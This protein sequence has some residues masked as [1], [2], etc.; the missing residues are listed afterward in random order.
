MQLD[1]AAILAGDAP[2]TNTADGTCNRER[3][4]YRVQEA[5]TEKTTQAND[6]KGNRNFCNRVTA[7]TVDFEHPK[8]TAP[9]APENAPGDGGLRSF[10]PETKTAISRPIL[11]Y[12]LTDRDN[13]SGRMVGAPGD[14]LADLVRDLRERYGARLDWVAVHE[15]FEERAAVVEYD[16]GQPRELAEQMAADEVRATVERAHKQA[17]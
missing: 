9:R 16:G 1:W 5:V 10:A 6:S 3:T 2:A 11:D 8:A 12:G 4:G 7:V 15:Q 14:V 17:S 13:S